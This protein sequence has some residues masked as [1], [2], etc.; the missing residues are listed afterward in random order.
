MK[1]NGVD[2]YISYP[3]ADFFVPILYKLN[4]TP[5]IVTLITLIIRLIALK[6]LYSKKLYSVIIILWTISWFTDA[7][8]GQLARKYNMTSKFGSFFD[9]FTDITTFLLLIFILYLKYYRRNKTPLIILFI[10]V[11]TISIL[12]GY[13]LPSCFN[14]NNNEKIWTHKFNFQLNKKECSLL[15][16]FDGGLNYII[17]ILFLIYTFYIKNR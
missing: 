1:T 10:I 9:F 8:D 2:K 14:N 15:K 7:M 5:N 4:F 17:I 11:I 6:L 3:V 13:I 12:W 16:H